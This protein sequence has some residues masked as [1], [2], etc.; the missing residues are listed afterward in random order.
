MNENPGHVWEEWTP[1][2][3]AEAQERARQWGLLRSCLYDRELNADLFDPLRV[4]PT[5][6]LRRNDAS[7]ETQGE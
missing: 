6:E 7:D 2:K 1:R 5:F 4:L 3:R